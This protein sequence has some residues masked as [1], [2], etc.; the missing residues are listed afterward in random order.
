MKPSVGDGQVKFPVPEKL[1]GMETARGPALL[2]PSGLYKEVVE[3]W[4]RCLLR[5]SRYKAKQ[6]KPD[7]KLS[8]DGRYLSFEEMAA[9]ERRML[10]EGANI[11]L[12]YCGRIEMERKREVR[13]RLGRLYEAIKGFVKEKGFFQLKMLVEDSL[14][15][16]FVSSNDK[17]FVRRIY[18]DL[19][20]LKEEGLIYSLGKKAKTWYLG[21]SDSDADSVSGEAG[22]EEGT[23]E[24]PPETSASEF[25]MLIPERIK[26]DVNISISF[27]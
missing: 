1:R 22:Q 18:N 20:L 24:A 6:I 3:G 10:K 8:S 17:Y 13:E 5:T 15:K 4:N 19:A 27:T 26:V 16:G 25:R 7:T 2:N 14:T 23:G 12:I 11:K 9:V 21:R